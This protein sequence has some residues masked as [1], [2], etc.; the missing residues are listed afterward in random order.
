MVARSG[1]HGQGDPSAATLQGG[2]FGRGDATSVVLADPRWHSRAMSEPTPVQ[3]AVQAQKVAAITIAEYDRMAAASLRPFW[4]LGPRADQAWRAS[5]LPG[6]PG[7]LLPGFQNTGSPHVPAGYDYGVKLRISP[8]GLSPAS[9]AASFAAP[10]VRLSTAVS[11]TCW[12]NSAFPPAFPISGS[13]QVTLRFPPAG[14]DGRGSPPSAV[15]SERYDFL[16]SH[17]LRL[18]DFAS[19]LRRRLPGFVFAGALPPPCRPDDGPGS[20][21]FTLAV[22][23]QRSCPRAR[24][25]SPRFPGGPSRDFAPVHDPGRPVA[26][27][28]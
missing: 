25:G 14:P 18:I 8:A 21:L 12:W 17:V 20:G 10:P 9:T 11:C 26:P 22:P 3:N 4:L 5:Q 16:P 2:R 19:R 15:L 13:V 6:L 27:R 24:A 28:Q 1:D 7:R 23:F